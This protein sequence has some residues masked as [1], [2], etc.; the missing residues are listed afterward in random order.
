[1]FRKPKILILFP[2]TL[3]LH[4]DQKENVFSIAWGDIENPMCEFIVSNEAINIV[5]AILNDY[6]R[7]QQE[8]FHL[9]CSHHKWVWFY[10]ETIPVAL[11][12]PCSAANRPR[13][14]LIDHYG[15]RAME[16]YVSTQIQGKQEEFT[17]SHNFT[18]TILTWN[19][20]GYFPGSSKLREWFLCQNKKYTDP[21]D[22]PDIIVIGLQE[23]CELTKLRGDLIREQEWVKYF[24]SEMLEIFSPDTYENV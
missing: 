23:M 11:H 22:A 17:T 1:M 9:E 6:P 16:A 2:L 19:A 20:G 14:L 10:Q 4:I 12:S 21:I 5:T 15:K 18:V 3:E 24:I 8:P 7:Y 13:S